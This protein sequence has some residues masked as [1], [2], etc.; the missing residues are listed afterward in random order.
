MDVVL[1]SGVL[2][3]KTR[4]FNTQNGVNHNFFTKPSKSLGG[5]VSKTNIKYQQCVFEKIGEYFV[6][7]PSC[8]KKKL[9]KPKM[10]TLESLKSLIFFRYVSDLATLVV[11][12]GIILVEV[13]WKSKFKAQF[14]SLN[15][16]S[17]FMRD[18]STATGIATFTMMLL[19]QW[20]V[21]KYGWGVAAKI[22]R[23]V[24]L[25]TGV[26]F[27]SLILFVGQQAPVIGSLGMTPLLAAVYVGAMQ[28]IFGAGYGSHASGLCLSLAGDVPS[29]RPKPQ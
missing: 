17:A 28:N 6:P 26:A 2:Q 29:E 25:I 15:E 4:A 23:T 16:Y 7:L 10:G 3:P 13:T 1:Q 5:V 24:F 22:T 27:F 20:I 21:N 8:N 19:S 14:P 12:Y 9:A 18:F 11:A